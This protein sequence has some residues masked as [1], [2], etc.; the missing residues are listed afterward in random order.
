[1]KRPFHILVLL[2]PFMAGML[3]VSCRRDN[4]A[5]VFAVP[6]QVTPITF[7]SLSGGDTKGAGESTREQ[8]RSRGFGLFVWFSPQDMYFEGITPGT[9]WLSNSSVSFIAADGLEDRWRCNPS[10]WW[11]VGCNLS[12]FAYAPYISSDDTMLSYP[13]EEVSGMPRGRFEQAT[14]VSEQVDFCLSA[15]VLDR[16]KAQGDVPIVFSHALTKVKFYFNSMGAGADDGSQTFMV[17]SMLLEN[18][19]GRNT[20]T[21]GGPSGFQWDALLRSDA[22]SRTESYSLSIQDGTLAA[23]PLPFEDDVAGLNGLDRFVC[24]NGTS[25][26]ALYL[27]PQPV[28]SSARVTLQIAMYNYNDVTGEW[29]E[30]VDYVLDPIVIPLPEATVWKAGQTV[31]YSSSLKVGNQVEFSVAV[32]D[33]N[34]NDIENVEFE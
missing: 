9:E 25:A 27:L 1:M 34:G 22:S 13:L 18:L 19:V 2:L 7:R 20:F 5:D 24:V 21:H 32:R 4:P 15:P 30:D 12:F 3:V 29:D 33:W 10:A 23:V 6:E 14:D 16:T 26:G 11:P 8:L 17:K 31:C 28:T